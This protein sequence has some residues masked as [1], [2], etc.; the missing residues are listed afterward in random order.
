LAREPPSR[1]PKGWVDAEAEERRMSSEPQRGNRL[2]DERVDVKVNG[3]GGV[4]R[5]D[6]A[7]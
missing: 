3:A 6:L 7:A 1:P 2:V 5:V 4:V